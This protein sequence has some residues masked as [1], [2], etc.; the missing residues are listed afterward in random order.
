MFPMTLAGGR[1]R[2]LLLQPRKYRLEFLASYSIE[3]PMVAGAS[4]W[5]S[6]GRRS[7]LLQRPTADFQG[8]LVGNPRIEIHMVAGAN[9][10]T[11][12]AALLQRPTA[13]FPGY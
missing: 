5:N 8:Y 10:S 9:S 6:H 7:K 3:I 2:S 12:S 4:N 13:D 1:C 11:L